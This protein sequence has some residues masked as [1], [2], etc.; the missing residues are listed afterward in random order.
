MVI[1][2]ILSPITKQWHTDCT[3]YQTN[4]RECNHAIWADN[5]F[6]FA[7]NQEEAQNIIGTVTHAVLEHSLE[8]KASAAEHMTAGDLKDT[9][10][11]LYTWLNGDYQP[12]QQVECMII[13][14]TSLYQEGST[15]QSIEHRRNKAER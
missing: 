3:G 8:S 6:L 7:D 5:V 9:K 1:G 2:L 11:D 14:G 4:N 15:H 10:L 12:I 13:F